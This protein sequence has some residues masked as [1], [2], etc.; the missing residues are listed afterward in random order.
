MMH[1]AWLPISLLRGIHTP[2]EA[3]RAP[4][5]LR[6]G[7]STTQGSRHRA[8]AASASALTALLRSGTAARR[9]QAR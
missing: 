8:G 1:P 4:R 9:R 5:P 2:A 3:G 7:R 6:L